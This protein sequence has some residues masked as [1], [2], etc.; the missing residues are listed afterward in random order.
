MKIYA[1]DWND[2]LID[3]FFLDGNLYY[4]KNTIN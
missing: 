1:S 3:Q 2:Q 4:K